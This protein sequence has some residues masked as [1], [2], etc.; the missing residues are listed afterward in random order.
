MRADIVTAA[1]ATAVERKATVNG[2]LLDR[3]S[4]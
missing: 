4:E 1:T 2:P 3:V